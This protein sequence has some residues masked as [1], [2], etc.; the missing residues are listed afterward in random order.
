MIEPRLR[1]LSA[2]VRLGLTGIVLSLL[3]GVWASLVHLR[4]HHAGRDGEPGVSM[5][6][7]IGAYHGLD[8]PAKLVVSLEDGHPDDLP[9]SERKIL[10]DWLGGGQVSEQYDALE[11]GDASPAEVIDRRCLD[12]HSRQSTE[13]DGIGKEVPLEYWDDV[14]KVAFSRS[15]EATPAEIQITSLHTHALAMALMTLAALGLLLATRWPRAIV[16]LLAAA[17][18][19]ALFVDLIS[20]LLTRDYVLLV[21]GI[22]GGG[23]LW[24][25][26]L[27]AACVGVLL[28]MWLPGGRRTR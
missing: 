26:C 9:E 1:A 19:L 2:P 17:G 12:C 28:D 13:G 4:D 11:L 20:Q 24:G 6:D 16:G 18:G 21:W 3:L 10:L 15:V 7:L 8:R 25:F 14:S 5:D 23:G 22:A 27:V